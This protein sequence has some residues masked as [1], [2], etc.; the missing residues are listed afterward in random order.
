LE[1]FITWMLVTPG[2]IWLYVG[3][4]ALALFLVVRR[5]DRERDD[6]RTKA[7]GHALAGTIR[8]CA[9][10]NS[11]DALSAAS[12]QLCSGIEG[13]EVDD[14]RLLMLVATVAQRARGDDVA[15]IDI[16]GEESRDVFRRSVAWPDEALEIADLFRVEPI[17]HDEIARLCNAASAETLAAMQLVMENAI[18]EKYAEALAAQRKGRDAFDHTAKTG[19]NAVWFGLGRGVR[20]LWQRWGRIFCFTVGGLMVLTGSSSGYSDGNM[21]QVVA[22]G[23][24]LLTGV[25]L[26]AIKKLQ[27][28][29]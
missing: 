1:D 17:D 27:P 20:W 16:L 19:W 23:A 8:A 22:G 26:T 24:L 15:G 14:I 28:R 11:G 12:W 5:D 9:T 18:V 13:F 4:M 6:A 10:S 7:F 29:T 25:G 21:S 3:L 2:M